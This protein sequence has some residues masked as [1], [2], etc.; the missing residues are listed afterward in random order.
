VDYTGDLKA[1]VW[2]APDGRWRGLAFAGSDGSSIDYRLVP[3]ATG[4]QQ[5]AATDP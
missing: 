1:R 3:A 2:Y 4:T 5:A